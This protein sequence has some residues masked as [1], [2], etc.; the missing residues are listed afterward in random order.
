MI[1]LMFEHCI[2]DNTAHQTSLTFELFTFS[3]CSIADGWTAESLHIQKR[4][5]ASQHD[6]LL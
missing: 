5:L 3:H 1:Y 2:K 6:H 4:K